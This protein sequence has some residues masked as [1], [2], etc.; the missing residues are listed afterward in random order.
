MVVTLTQSAVLLYYAYSLH[1]HIVYI[2][3]PSKNKYFMF[4]PIYIFVAHKI[5]VV[6]APKGQNALSQA[7]SN[8]L[9]VQ[10]VA[11]S[12]LKLFSMPILC[13]LSVN[14][15]MKHLGNDS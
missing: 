5:V 7:I 8:L 15:F 4:V 1:Y 11:K 13:Q 12:S 3:N 14:S 9:V 2:I 10:N 6:D